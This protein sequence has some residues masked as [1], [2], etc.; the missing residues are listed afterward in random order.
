MC[1]SATTKLTRR[2][3]M[4]HR[5]YFADEREASGD[6]VYSAIDGSAHAAFYAQLIA[7]ETHAPWNATFLK[8]Q[9]YVRFSESVVEDAVVMNL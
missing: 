4:L 5:F 3:L 2:N 7:G 8:G 6:P 9:G 1:Q